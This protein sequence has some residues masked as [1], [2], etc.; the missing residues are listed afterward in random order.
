M[1]EPFEVGSVVRDPSAQRT[2]TIIDRA[3][4][5][6]HPKA[7]PVHNYLI[8]WEDGQIQAVSQLAFNG[9]MGFELVDQA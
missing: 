6:S 2:G 1:R 9:G 3:R 8:R 7:E 5:Y 4:Q